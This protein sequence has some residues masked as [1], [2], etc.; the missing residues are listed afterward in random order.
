MA[1]LENMQKGKTGWGVYPPHLYVS[2]KVDPRGM[3]KTKTISRAELTA[4]AAAIIHGYSQIVAN[5]LTLWHQ[6]KK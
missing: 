3:R 1:A 4:K 6:I 5:S 2:H